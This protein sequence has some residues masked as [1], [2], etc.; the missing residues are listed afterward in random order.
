MADPALTYGGE[1]GEY[2]AYRKQAG[3]YIEWLTTQY[4]LYL[5]SRAL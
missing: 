2:A 3:D 1:N 5:Q 4:K